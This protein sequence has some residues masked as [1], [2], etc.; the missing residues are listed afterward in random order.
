[1]SIS[2]KLAKLEQRDPPKWPL[3]PIPPCRM[4]FCGQT[5]SGKTMALVSMLLEPKMMVWDAVFWIAPKTSW[6][7]PKFGPLR[8]KYGEYLK[9]FEPSEGPGSL[10]EAIDASHKL[11]WDVLCV[12][13]DVMSLFGPKNKWMEEL[14]THGRHRGVSTAI[15]AQRLNPPHSRVLRVNTDYFLCWKS[16]FASEFRNLAQQICADPSDAKK[17][18]DAYR[19]VTK[20]PHGFIILDLKGQSTEELPLAVRDSSWSCLIPHLWNIF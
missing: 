13:D 10:Q 2:A 20:K 8:K 4:Y 1:M 15:L 16:S 7:Q 5:N 18:T 17:L 9:F 14:V 19:R 3:A 11:G 6:N 12:M